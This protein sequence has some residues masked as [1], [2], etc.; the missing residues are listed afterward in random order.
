MSWAFPYFPQVNA[1][2]PHQ[3][4]VN[5]GTGNGLLQTTSNYLSQCWL[6]SLS[7]YIFNN[8]LT[9][10]FLPWISIFSPWVHFANIKVDPHWKV[11]VLWF[12]WKFGIIKKMRVWFHSCK[13]SGVN[14][15]WF[16]RYGALYFIGCYPKTNL[17][18]LF[19][20]YP[21]ILNGYLK[22]LLILLIEK[23]PI[24]HD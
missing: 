13:A 24:T 17:K 2:R 5:I 14:P 10:K 20:F 3:W 11:K 21:I 8:E 18:H 23:Q 4:L 6:R 15:N 19:F 1:I 16:C 12:S 9:S 22:R 7:T